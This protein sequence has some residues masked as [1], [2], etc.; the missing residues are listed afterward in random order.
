MVIS[1]QKEKFGKKES[2]S[3]NWMFVFLHSLAKIR[4]SVCFLKHTWV[5]ANTRFLKSDNV[6]ST[7]ST[8]SVQFYHSWRFGAIS[9][10][11]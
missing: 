3:S 9:L 6:G 8:E 4:S 7:W 1:S 10:L 2:D 5:S 11:Y